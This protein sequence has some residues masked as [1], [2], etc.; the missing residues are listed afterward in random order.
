MIV[1]FQFDDE[2]VAVVEPGFPGNGLASGLHP[3]PE[4]GGGVVG[5]AQADDMTERQQIGG[6]LY[7]QVAAVDTPACTQ[8]AAQIVT[9]AAG[10]D[11]ER[12]LQQLLDGQ[13]A[14]GLRVR[15]AGVEYLAVQQPQL[16]ELVS[17]Y[18]LR[19]VQV[20]A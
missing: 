14:P 11:L 16:L 5:A 15:I 2:A 18:M 10:I 4:A 9:Q 1:L 3:D 6:V 7:R 19:I 20:T 8:G 13:L 17:K 12:L